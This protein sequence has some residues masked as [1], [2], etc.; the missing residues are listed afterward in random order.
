[1]GSKLQGSVQEV[2]LV[3]VGEWWV[4]QQVSGMSHAGVPGTCSAGS[5]WADPM[6]LLAEKSVGRRKRADPTTQPFCPE[7]L[8]LPRLETGTV[9][10]LLIPRACQL[11]LSYVEFLGNL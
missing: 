10:S 4:E 6:S 11:G 3:L 7:L 1:M 8:L 9:F 2:V 5:F